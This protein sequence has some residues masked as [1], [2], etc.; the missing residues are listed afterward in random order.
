MS[1]KLLAQSLGRDPSFK[2]VGTAS[3]SEILPLAVHKT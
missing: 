1:S 2:I 3:A